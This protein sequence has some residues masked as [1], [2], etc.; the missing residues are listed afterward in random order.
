MFAG[1]GWELQLDR[2]MGGALARG[3]APWLH[4]ALGAAARGDPPTRPPSR[5]TVVATAVET[6]VATAVETAV[7]TAAATAVATAFPTAVATVVETAVETAVAPHVGLVRRPPPRSDDEL[8]FTKPDRNS[9][10]DAKIGYRYVRNK[11]LVAFVCDRL[12]PRPPISM[13]K[14]RV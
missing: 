13:L 6:A 7:A 11:R 5:P 12:P 10:L 1:R 14:L 9:M 8:G 3:A 2:L 4:C